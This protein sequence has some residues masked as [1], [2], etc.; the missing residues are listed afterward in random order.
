[1]NLRNTPSVLIALLTL[2]ACGGGSSGSESK[3]NEQSPQN[4]IHAYVDGTGVCAEVIADNPENAEQFVG[5]GGSYGRC[6]D[7]NKMAYCANM[8]SGQNQG[9][10]VF[11]YSG[12]QF[13]EAVFQE[14]CSHL[15]GV[16]TP[17]DSSGDGG[18]SER[19]ALEELT[20]DQ[21]ATEFVNYIDVHAMYSGWVWNIAEQKYQAIPGGEKDYFRY[22][23]DTI[24]NS[25]G[26]K[27]TVLKEPSDGSG[28]LLVSFNHSTGFLTQISNTR[29]SDDEVCIM[30]NGADIFVSE[31]IFNDLC[32]DTEGY[33]FYVDPL[34]DSSWSPVSIPFIDK[35]RYS[36][37][38]RVSDQYGLLKGFIDSTSN[39]Q[40]IF[41]RYTQNSFIEY[42]LKFTDETQDTGRVESLVYVSDENILLKFNREV[43]RF[44]LSQILNG[45]QGTNINSTFADGRV[46]DDIRLHQ[47]LAGTFIRTTTYNYGN[48][49]HYQEYFT[50]EGTRLASLN[51]GL[52]I[53]SW[54][55]KTSGYYVAV[56]TDLSDESGQ[57]FNLHYYNSD[58]ERLE[59][60][61][62][63]IP[64]AADS[65]V[66]QGNNSFA[67]SSKDSINA[68]I[69][70]T[71]SVLSNSVLILLEA[72]DLPY[73]GRGQ[74]A[75]LIGMDTSSGDLTLL[76]E[77]GDWSKYV[78][79]I[80][81]SN[82]IDLTNNYGCQMG[83][84]LHNGE[85]FIIKNIPNL[86]GYM[87]GNYLTEDVTYPQ[88]Q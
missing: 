22:S 81:L 18:G 68:V 4:F 43:Y 87:H 51:I 79:S 54:L 15:G 49:D 33:G 9:Y 46:L 7:T 17:I 67:I 25:L 35:V 57:K 55:M 29:W 82:P 72:A 20:V 73:Y 58:W 76:S 78:G 39:N 41:Y 48:T 38:A 2:T 61:D 71:Q 86:V 44:T 6:P 88:Q 28:S 59:Q 32:W 53:E 37:L 80:P 45:E 60:L 65:C 64:A 13:D 75:K 21:S 47:S 5:G 36:E 70:S 74:D 11:F 69:G 8:P 19:P 26:Q 50:L 30:Q 77:N 23:H 83:Y 24:V 84:G 3:N 12:T 16:Y 14:S 31:K 85:Q 27:I 52:N 66:V 1:M 10:A 40:Q 62:S 63:T 34:A 56:Y 42:E